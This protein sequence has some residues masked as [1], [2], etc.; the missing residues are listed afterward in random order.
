MSAFTF[1]QSK[2]ATTKTPPI[3]KP[4]KGECPQRALDNL[5]YG[6]KKMVFR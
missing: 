3:G 4:P 1:Y 5:Q 6:S 2:L